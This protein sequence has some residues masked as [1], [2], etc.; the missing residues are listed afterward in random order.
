MKNK[1]NLLVTLSDRNFVS[2]AKQ[3]FSSVYWNAGWQGDYM[4][5]S[6]Q[7]DADDV[8]WFRNR[9]II[10]KECPSLYDGVLYEN[11][12]PSTVLS[13]F[14]LFTEPFKKWDNIIFLDADIIVRASIDFLSHPPED[15]LLCIKSTA[16]L[17]KYFLSF[18]KSKEFELLLEEFDL[19][20][21]AFNSGVMSFNSKMIKKNTFDDLLSIFNKYKNI[22]IGDDPILNLYFRNQWL[23]PPI[24]YNVRNNYLCVFKKH[25]GIILHFET[26]S[27]GRRKAF[28]PWQ[29]E[30]PYYKEWSKNLEKAEKIDIN[31]I[32]Q[33]V[34]WSPLKKK[35]NIVLIRSSLA[36]SYVKNHIKFIISYFMKLPLPDLIISKVGFFIKNRNYELYVK[37]REILRIDSGFDKSRLPIGLKNLTANINEED[38][39]NISKKSISNPFKIIQ[40]FSQFDTG[41]MYARGDLYN[42]E[43]YLNF[44]SFLLSYLTLKKY[45]GE[46]VMYC[47]QKAYDTFIKHIPYDEIIIKENRFLTDKYW[48]AYKLD[49]IADVKTPFIHVDS[50]VFIFD[51]LFRPFIENQD[52]YD[53]IVQNILPKERNL[54]LDFVKNNATYLKGNNLLVDNYDGKC[55][56]CGVIGMGLET[57]EKF[58]HNT[59]KLLNAMEKEEVKDMIHTAMVLEELTFYFTVLQNDLKVYDILPY[60]D[61]YKYDETLAGDKHYY[62]HLWFYTKF[63]KKNIDLVKNKIKTHFSDMYYLVERYEDTLKKNK[64]KLYYF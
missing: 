36:L 25:N 23:E 2:Q 60:D 43:V 7:I 14:Y 13:K 38:G 48:N 15:K 50:D 57:K 40:S 6:H 64:I 17:K 55:L 39:K 1:K 56:S 20:C 18:K 61:V 44:Y 63:Q 9:G 35:I 24:I 54:I 3:L 8:S 42:K 47:N 31:I 41:V 34:V 37:L 62:T 45:Y 30:N 10:V 29:K 16:L 19:S 28:K 12:Y 58:I 22:C 11:L 5:L 4:L 52:T 53:V 32:P 49:V 21:P 46:V 59:E 27:T 33:A 51:D 26:P